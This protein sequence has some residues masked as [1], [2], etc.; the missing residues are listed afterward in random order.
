MKIKYTSETNISDSII[1]EIVNEYLNYNYLDEVTSL[2]SCS[3]ELIIKA[4]TDSDAIEEIFY[5]FDSD[6]FKIEI[7]DGDNN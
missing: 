7:L 5:E 1:L 2:E 4:L 6:K 3:K